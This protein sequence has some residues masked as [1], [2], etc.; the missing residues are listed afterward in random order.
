MDV[1]RVQD[2]VVDGGECGPQSGQRRGGIVDGVGALEERGDRALVDRVQPRLSPLRELVEAIAQR[3]VKP[4]IGA[5]Q[6]NRR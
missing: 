6:L 2:H 3:D 4:R 5:R 1:G